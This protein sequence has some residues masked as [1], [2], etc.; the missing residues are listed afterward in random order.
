MLQ[1]KSIDDLK[2]DYREL[3]QEYVYYKQQIQETLKGLEEIEDLMDNLD[4]GENE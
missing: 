3:F 1:S 4:T 2:R